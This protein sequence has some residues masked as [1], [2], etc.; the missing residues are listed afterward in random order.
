MTK[1]EFLNGYLEAEWELEE[2]KRARRKLHEKIDAMD[3]YSES[4]KREKSRKKLCALDDKWDEL[5]CR[6]QR[7]KLQVHK[8]ICALKD[9]RQRKVLYAWYIEGLKAHEISRK[10]HYAV[11][12]IHALHR[13]GVKNVRM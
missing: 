7:K 3:G 9:D 2:I 12:H 10:L 13:L 5:E 11:N 1:Q 8:A 6:A 4:D